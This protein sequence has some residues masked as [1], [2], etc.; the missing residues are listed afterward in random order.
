MKYTKGPWK[1]Y[2]KQDQN[3]DGF[4]G[5]STDTAYFIANADYQDVSEQEGNK[6][7]IESAPELLEALSGVVRTLEAFKYNTQLGS[8]Q[9]ARLEK[10]KAV[11]EK[12]KGN[13]NE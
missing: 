1:V 4:D 12:V 7:L 13:T 6:R 9:T 10:A 5:A 2:A 8:S 11:I 3:C